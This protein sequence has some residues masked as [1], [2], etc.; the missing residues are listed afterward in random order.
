MNKVRDFIKN[1]YHFSKKTAVLSM[2]YGFLVGLSY[3]LGYQLEK[4][5]MTLPGI[6]GKFKIFILAL[7]IMIPVSLIAYS[8]FM[9]LDKF[10][11]SKGKETASSTCSKKVFFRFFRKR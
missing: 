8:A 1:N 7:L 6:T 3:V 9:F 4:M 11:S 2:I 10:Y 5:G